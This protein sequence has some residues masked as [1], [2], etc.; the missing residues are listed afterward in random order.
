MNISVPTQWQDLHPWQREKICFLLLENT[1][2][3]EANL[4]KIVRILFLNK[5]TF[6]D[7]IR[8]A[9]LFKQVP[10]S[11]LI[12]Y[13][14]F[15]FKDRNLHT[16]PKLSEK[17]DTPLPRLADCSIKQFSVIDT[18]FYRWK[19]ES[20][21]LYLKQLVASL[22]RI[23]GND[24]DANDLPKVAE[25]TD[26]ISAEKRAEIGFAY[27]CVREYIINKYPKIFQ[28]TGEEKKTEEPVFQT[29]KKQTYTPFSKVITVMAMDERQPL[30]NLHDCNRT[31]LYDFL[32][33][34]Q[35]LIIRNE[36]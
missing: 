17:L 12:S 1:E 25:I 24:F 21:D 29:S 4:L 28:P 9:R 26:K 2:N 33:V 36:Q 19:T 10:V 31:R 32:D 20:N 15:L 14:D 8:T 13:A 7:K 23:K 16:F 3:F 6:R 18:L 22:Y 27:S 35:E 5:N 34:F 30:G 11:Q